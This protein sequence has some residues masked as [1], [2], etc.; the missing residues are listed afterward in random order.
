MKGWKRDGGRGQGKN[1]SF[2]RVPSEPHLRRLSGYDELFMK[3]HVSRGL[4]EWW[5]ITSPQFPLESR[6]LC[7][8]FREE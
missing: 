7:S 3:T 5:E 4:H 8:D 2:K 1:A 6:K